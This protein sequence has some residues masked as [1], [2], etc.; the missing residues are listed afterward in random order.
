VAG[1]PSMPSASYSSLPGSEADA[2]LLDLAEP[3]A[4]I[5]RDDA[6]VGLAERLGLG[7]RPVAPVDVRRLSTPHLSR[8]LLTVTRREA[9]NRPTLWACLDP[10]QH[11]SRHAPTKG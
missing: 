11:V 5:A 9:A 10:I 8:R 6:A 3:H 4:Q 2:A 1:S 7:Q